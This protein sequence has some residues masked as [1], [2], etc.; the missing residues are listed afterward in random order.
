MAYDSPN[1]EV[2]REVSQAGIAG[3]DGANMAKFLFF[4]KT[5]LKKVHALITV[6][7]TAA[8][9]GIDILVGTESVGEI[10]IGTDAAGS[11]KSSALLNADVPANG[12]VSLDGKTDSATMKVSVVL[13]HE[14]EP[15]AA[16]S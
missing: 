7:G 3:A 4:Q 2:R 14:V 16:V 13:E 15:D 9:A 11:V 8:G 12:V 1:A 6:M 5:K 10:V